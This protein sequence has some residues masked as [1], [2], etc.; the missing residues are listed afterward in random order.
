MKRIERGSGI[1]MKKV[2]TI[3]EELKKE[4]KKTGF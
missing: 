4:K 2:K 3:E 1:W